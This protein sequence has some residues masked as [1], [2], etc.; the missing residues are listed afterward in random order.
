MKMSQDEAKA[1][2]KVLERSI[3]E[4]T[5]GGIGWCKEISAED[6]NGEAIS[7]TSDDVKKCCLY[8]IVGRA[9]E[10]EFSISTTGVIPINVSN[11]YSDTHAELGK[12]VTYTGRHYNTALSWWNDGLEGT[13]EVCKGEVISLIKDTIDQ[14][15][16]AYLTT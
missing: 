15:T 10:L 5:E 8:G 3:Y 2:V 9:L 13:E 14:V 7:P 4:Y 16:G 6:A 11:A 12:C 1:V